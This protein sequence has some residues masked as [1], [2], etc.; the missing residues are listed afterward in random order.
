MELFASQEA[1]SMSSVLLFLQNLLLFTTSLDRI[2]LRAKMSP[3]VKVLQPPNT[4]VTILTI[5]V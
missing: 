3:M 4:I 1:V 5:I 2:R